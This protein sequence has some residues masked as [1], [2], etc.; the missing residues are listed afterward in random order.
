MR[1]S[2]RPLTLGALLLLALV[3]RTPAADAPASPLRQAHAHNDYEHPR[4]LFD[5]LDQGFCSVEADIYLVDGKLLVAHDRKDLKPDRTLEKLYLDPLRERAKANG[6]S[7]YRGGPPFWLLIDVKTEAKSTYAALHPVLERYADIL[8]VTTDGKFERKG[9][10]VV[11]SG[12]TDRAG[13]T[14]QTR[15]YAAIDGRPPDLETDAPAHL[16][17]WVSDNWRLHFHWAGDG[18]MPDAEKAKLRDFVAKAHRQ[19]RLVRFWA[20]PESTAVWAELRAAGVDLINTDKL[21][22]LRAFLTAEK[23]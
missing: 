20:T 22:E 9:V 18:P 8:S 6:G 21:A 1:P 12:N 2:R 17:P 3:G 15:R 11:V 16:V 14:A 19:G 10:T 4:P 13:I 5:A 23:H 7:V